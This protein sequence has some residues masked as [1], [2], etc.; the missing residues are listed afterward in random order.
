MSAQAP[1]VFDWLPA[2]LAPVALRLARADELEYQLGWECLNWSLHALDLEQ[3]KRADGLLDVVVHAVRPIPPVAAML[4]SEIVNHLR[5][6]IDNVM[7]Y[8]VEALG[9]PLTPSAAAQ[10][11][12][13]IQ[14]S[15]INLQNW[16]T[17]RK[18]KVPGFDTGKSFN[19]ASRVFSHITALRW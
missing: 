15:A 7:F 18:K 11:A 4:F 10:V 5:A 6:A 12:M 1:S 9:G 14:E 19:D 13:P 8:V 3:V 2:G 16:S 17:R